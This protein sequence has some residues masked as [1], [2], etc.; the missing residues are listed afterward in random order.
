MHVWTCVYICQHRK[1]SREFCNYSNHKCPRVHKTLPSPRHRVFEWKPLVFAARWPRIAE[2]AVWVFAG[3]REVLGSIWRKVRWFCF[4]VYLSM[5]LLTWQVWVYWA[6]N[7][8][9]DIVQPRRALRNSERKPDPARSSWKVLLLLGTNPEDW[10][11]R[12]LGPVF[13]VV[14]VWCFCFVFSNA[15]SQHNAEE[16]HWPFGLGGR[17]MG[18]KQGRC[19]SR[20]VSC[21]P[22][23]EPVNPPWS[24]FVLGF[25]QR[26]HN[27]T[28]NSW[29]SSLLMSQVCRQ[30]NQSKQKSPGVCSFSDAEL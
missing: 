8:P 15:K 21:W 20:S 2:H 6:R 4:L 24:L 28:L 29:E 5:P 1:A 18:S 3:S 10:I 11:G 7:A 26:L 17:F 9:W 23:R 25:W 16:K 22:P 12:T 19:P 30:E 27:Q 14:V 13:V